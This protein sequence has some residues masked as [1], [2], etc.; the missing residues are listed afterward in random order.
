MEETIHSPIMNICLFPESRDVLPASLDDGSISAA[1]A[2]PRAP[3][4]TSASASLASDAPARSL[5]DGTAVVAAGEHETQSPFLQPIRV[6]KETVD[7]LPHEDPN[8][9]SQSYRP[10]LSPLMLEKNKWMNAARQLKGA[11]LTRDEQDKAQHDFEEFWKNV[12]D[13]DVYDE[14]HQEWVREK[15]HQHVRAHP[16][17]YTQQWGG[18]SFMSPINST[19]FCEYIKDMEGRWPNDDEITDAKNNESR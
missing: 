3:P 6:V 4:A 5:K 7:I 17:K 9:S 8:T 11:P 19:E 18:G 12:V 16:N 2:P 15:K 1:L 10:G 14:A 13:Q